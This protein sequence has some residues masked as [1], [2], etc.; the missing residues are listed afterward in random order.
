MSRVSPPHR[1]RAPR[2]WLFGNVCHRA[3]RDNTLRQMVFRHC[4]PRSRLSHNEFVRLNIETPAWH[5]HES[6]VIHRGH[7][8][9]EDEHPQLSEILTP[10]VKIRKTV[11]AKDS[12]ADP[13]P[14]A[15]QSA[16]KASSE[17]SAVPA[18][19]IASRCGGNFVRQIPLR[20][21]AFYRAMAA[22]KIERSDEAAVAPAIAQ[23]ASGPAL[24]V[25]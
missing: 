21:V 5:Q 2:E 17:S 14:S 20:R 13:I 19:V 23:A 22:D 12:L 3:T 1:R 11:P 9:P 18:I 16:A 6:R 4:R 24:T 15:G 25:A 8:R 10:V 7:L